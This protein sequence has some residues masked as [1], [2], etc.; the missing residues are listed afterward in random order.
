MDFY[1]F[2]KTIHFFAKWNC[3][4]KKKCE[5]NSKVLGRIDTNESTG[6]DNYVSALRDLTG[7]VA[8]NRFR[9]GSIIHIS[10]YSRSECF[11]AQFDEGRG[12][13]DKV[14][15]LSEPL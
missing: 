1:F 10:I 9:L 4:A 14:R 8:R 5:I 11:R 7:G 12:F 6:K 15:D 13:S 3:E 2:L